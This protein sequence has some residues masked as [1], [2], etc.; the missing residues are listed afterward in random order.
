MRKPAFIYN[1]HAFLIAVER[2]CNLPG[3]LAVEHAVVLKEALAHD[4]LRGMRM[5]SPTCHGTP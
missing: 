5:H 2:A 1:N 4:L 3:T